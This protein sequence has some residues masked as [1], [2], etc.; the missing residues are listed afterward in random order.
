ML[1]AEKLLFNAYFA[2]GR[3]G[4][5]GLKLFV[6]AK[7][8]LQ[9]DNNEKDAEDF[10]NQPLGSAAMPNQ[11][12]T[13][14]PAAAMTVEEE[15]AHADDIGQKIERAGEEITRQN[16]GEDDEVC[17]T[18]RRKD[19]PERRADDDVAPGAVLI[20]GA[21][22]HVRFPIERIDAGNHVPELTSLTMPKMSKR[23]PEKI[24][25]KSSGMLMKAVLTFEDEGEDEDRGAQRSDNG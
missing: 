13:F 12:T 7:N 16:G 4:Q 1:G 14:C 23:P 8:D 19:W 9:A 24:C 21:D 5:A 2:E 11:L 10:L 15:Y 18:A 20:T 22:G 6:E 17:R 3:L 25:Q